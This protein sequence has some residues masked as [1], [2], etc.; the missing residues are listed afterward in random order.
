MVP[1][2]ILIIG[3]S[4]RAA[5]WSTRRAGFAP[6][7][8]D[9]FADQDLGH[10]ARVLETKNSPVAADLPSLAR[11][12]PPQRW[13]YVGGL[14]NEPEIVDDISRYHH[15][16]GNP[17]S[18]LRIIRDPFRWTES[19]RQAGLP[20]LEVL[21][22]PPQDGRPNVWI[23]KAFR[24]V[25]GRSVSWWGPGEPVNTGSFLQQYRAGLTIGAQF[26][27]TRDG[28]EYLGACRLFAGGPGTAGPFVYCGCLG[29]ID[30]TPRVL[31]QLQESAEVLTRLAGLTGLFGIDFVV[32]NEGLAWPLEINPRYTASMEILERSQPGW[33]SLRAHVEACEETPQTQRIPGSPTRI[34]AKSVLFAEAPLTWREDL[35]ESATWKVDR[36]TLADIPRNGV[37]I[38]PGEPILSVLVEGVDLDAAENQLVEATARWRLDLKQFA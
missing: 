10:L 34:A 3:A 19:L 9:H 1:Q 20:H 13:F 12:L 4:A 30:L 18:A 16:L 23:C 24:S 26:L 27:A 6:S 2:P 33:S 31:T 25:G 22:Q 21:R 15:L 35:V 11:T 38:A 37:N 32:D 5:A 14:E 29:P 17:G 28:V 36:P 8:I 7:A